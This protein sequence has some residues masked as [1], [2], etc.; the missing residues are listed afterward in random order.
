MAA[1]TLKHEQHYCK[2]LTSFKQIH[3]LT[4]KMFQYMKTHNLQYAL[5]QNKTDFAV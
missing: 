3:F 4:S 1:G 5:P 2:L